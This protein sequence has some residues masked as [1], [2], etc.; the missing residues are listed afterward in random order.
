MR[1][2]VFEK[3][4]SAER[5]LGEVAADLDVDAVDV[6]G[7]K[8]LV[9]LFTC[10]ERFAVAGRG[11]AAGR[12]AK[13]VNWKQSAHRNPA[14]WLASA[15]GV[16][17]GAAARE[18][19]TARKLEDLPATAKAFR[20]GE[21]S[22]AQAAEIAASASVDPEAEER[23]LETVRDGATFRTVRDQCRETAM[24]ATEDEAKT[25]WLH[26]TRSACTYTDTDG[27]LVVRS[28]LSPDVGARVRSVIERKTDEIF[29][30]AR[31]AGTT[32][33]R[34]AY[35]A[36]ALSALILGETT[37]PPPDVRLHLDD[38]VLARGWAEPGERCHL[39][40]VGPIPVSMARSLLQDARIT[41]FGHDEHGDI[42]TVSSPTRTI[43]ARLRR[44]V[45]AAYLTCGTSACDS[46]FRL[47]IDHIVELDAGGLTAKD[48][49]WR[50]CG[51]HHQLKT[52]RG[53]RV[54]RGRDGNPDLVPPDHPDRLPRDGSG[55]DPSGEPP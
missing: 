4:R 53:W 54:V 8:K 11:L 37:A 52:H 34:S 51:H 20:S 17:V 30:A 22:E 18:L 28:E 48:N 49:L 47:E 36:D 38:A 16:S 21:L 12:V 13:A 29:R 25:R 1:A 42:T 10:C 43:P 41:T 9:D 31:A 40:G 19:D 2:S 3:L 55:C 35:A 32:E 24:R 44:W 23:L 7:A 46:T 14:E 6:E 27:H 26:D 50:L 5:L 45:E 15:T 39:E 33:L